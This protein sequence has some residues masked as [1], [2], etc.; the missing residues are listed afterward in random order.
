MRTINFWV[1]RFKYMVKHMNYFRYIFFHYIIF[2]LYNTMKTLGKIS[3]GQNYSYT[4][5]YANKRTYPDDE[6]DEY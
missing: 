2:D 1:G 4:K 3:L 5:S 6:L